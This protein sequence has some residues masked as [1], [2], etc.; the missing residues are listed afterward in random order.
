[1]HAG[2]ASATTGTAALGREGV[3]RHD[4]VAAA[5]GAAVQQRGGG[6]APPGS[7]GAAAEVAGGSSSEARGHR[8]R[9]SKERSKKRKAAAAAGLEAP[10][11]AARRQERIEFDEFEDLALREAGAALKA[12]GGGRFSIVEAVAHLKR[13]CGSDWCEVNLHGC[14]PS[15][16]K[17][18]SGKKL[19]HA[20]RDQVKK[21]SE[22]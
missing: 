1:V 19:Y 10:A 15:S 3:A 17:G 7:W 6:R 2:F 16:V 5:V 9:D 11:D 21:Y 20:I 12:R 22:Q 4:G 18:S 14:T 13:V 8:D